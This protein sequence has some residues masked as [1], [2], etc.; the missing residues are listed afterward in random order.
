MIESLVRPNI[1]RLK[2]Y[3]CA[4]NLYKEGVLLDANENAFGSVIELPFDQELNRY[5]DPDS[6]MLKEELA[7]FLG[8]EVENLFVG[9]GSDEVIDL[10]IRVFVGENEEVIICEPTYGM[11][12]V[13]AEMNGA[14]VKTCLLNRDFQI[15]F[16]SIEQSISLKS[17][18]LFCCSPNS[19]IGNMLKTQDIEKLCKIFPGIVVLDEAYIEF[20]SEPS[21]VERLS[22]FQNLVILRTFSKAWG[23]AGLRVGYCVADREIINYL[24]KVKPPYNLNR[25]SCLLATKALKNKERLY[26]MKNQILQ[27]RKWLKRQL[28]KMGF[29]VY[30]SETNFLLVRMPKASLVVQKLVRD[31]G[32]VVRDFS[33]KPLLEDCVRITVGTF[34]Q[35]NAFIQSLINLSQ[36]SP[37]DF[38]S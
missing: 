24:N 34:K 32:I 2:A 10:L 29:V 16:Q 12:K 1:R 19:P 5:P 11:Y 9:V 3:T 37:V 25:I 38:I 28:E 33:D 8:V 30:P 20:S 23:L 4:R 27:E 17:K 13:A 35:N 31:F 26:D 15:D 36:C 14:V 18:L 21:F 7:K 22:D 6:L